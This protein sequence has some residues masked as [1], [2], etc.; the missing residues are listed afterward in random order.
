MARVRRPAGDRADR[1]DYHAHHGP[2]RLESPSWLA[3]PPSWIG[4]W[5][6]S[7]GR[8]SG[9]HDRLIGGEA[10]IGKTRLV[11][12]FRIAPAHRARSRSVAAPCGWATMRTAI[13][14]PSSRPCAASSTTRGRSRSARCWTHR[15][16][17]WRRSSR[18][19][20][21]RAA[22]L[23][24]KSNAGLGADPAL[25]VVARAS[26][27]ARRGRPAVFVVED[28]HWADRSTRDLFRVPRPRHERRASAAGGHLPQR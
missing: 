28:L 10:G 27:A 23:R 15:R 16:P 11:N 19:S 18:S 3:A 26:P 12:E 5:R 2:P 8:Q 24:P 14:R 13:S 20:G 7:I 22:S 4:C 17:S 1:R 9:V 6:R 21:R 25:R